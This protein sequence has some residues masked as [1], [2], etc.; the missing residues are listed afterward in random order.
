MKAT[1]LSQHI[2][3]TYRSLRLGLAVIAFAFSIVLAV[4]GYVLAN[5][6]LQGSMSAYYH[7]GDGAM[8]T[9]FVGVLFAVGA[10]LFLYRGFTFFEDY[11]LNFAGVLALGVALFPMDWPEGTDGKFSKHGACAVAFFV[12]IAYV[13]IFRAGD[14][15]TLIQDE[16][17]RRRYQRSYRLLG[18]AMVALPALA[19]LLLSILKLNQ[20]VTFFVEAAGVYVFSA[21]WIVKS[22]EITETNADKKAARGAL[23]AR[24]HGLSDAFR[25]VA[26]V[27]QADVAKDADGGAV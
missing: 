2:A 3:A 25:Q 19:F 12:C 6:S 8:R 10:I 22:R 1:D 23:Q 21:Y 18:V 11:A 9:E 4:G 20:S 17:R 24:P 16:A 14:T 26:V 13:C 7:A 5:E 27:A 15:L